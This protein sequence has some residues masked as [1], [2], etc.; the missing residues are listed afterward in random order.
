MK[1]CFSNFTLK[2]IAVIFMLVD[3]IGYFFIRGETYNF[4]R[5]CG[6]LAMPI[7]F[8]LF[9]EGFLKT[10]SRKKHLTRLVIYSIIM[11]TGNVILHHTLKL[12]YPVKTNILL[13]MLICYVFL[14]IIESNANLFMKILGS[15]V[16][17]ILAYFAEYGVLTILLT[18]LF[19]CYL[20]GYL[21]KISF[22]VVYVLGSVVY[23]YFFT[24][25]IQIYMVLALP[26]MLLYNGKVGY[27]N[28]IIQQGFYLFYILH[29]WI[30]L[31]LKNFVF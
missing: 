28:K 22:S 31:L 5:A 12:C 9:V 18:I 14:L 13:S 26:F 6:R 29:L 11:L 16:M 25:N 4:F 7:F 30:F 23:C 8:F 2:I 3:H 27:K 24:A 15:G 10:K 21:N 1:P 19:Y 20:K 17:F